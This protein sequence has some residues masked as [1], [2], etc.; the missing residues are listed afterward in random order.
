GLR[1][2]AL[3]VTKA[4]G[5]GEQ[6]EFDGGEIPLMIERDD[7]RRWR[8]SASRSLA[9]LNLK[10]GDMLVYRAVATD[11]RPG[12]GSASSD[13]FFIEISKLGGADGD[14]FTLP[15]EATRYALSQRMLIIRTERLHQRRAST[16]QG[17]LAETALNL[18]VEQ[19]MIRAELVFMLGAAAGS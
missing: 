12:G 7:A 19:R 10:E 17:D 11:T 3:H 16:A 6:F 13:A 4:S 2:L 18:A 9:E 5:S 15:E 1:A 8:G 14:A